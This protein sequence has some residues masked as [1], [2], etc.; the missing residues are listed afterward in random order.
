MSRGLV[1]RAEEGDM[2]CSL[3]AVF[4]PATIVGVSL[5]TDNQSA[6]TLQLS[7]AEKT[8]SLLPRTV[9]PSKKAV[10]DDF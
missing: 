4:E 9:R 5:F 10:K 2:G 8:F 6:M 3:G 7:N 1:Y